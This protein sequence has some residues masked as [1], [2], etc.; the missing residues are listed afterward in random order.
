MTTTATP[1]PSAP[2]LSA[3]LGQVPPHPL[4]LGLAGPAGCGKS[5]T[6]SLLSG[7]CGWARLSFADPLRQLLLALHPAWDLWH[8]GPGKDLTPPDGGL[9]P[10]EMMR[11][12]GDWAK[13]YVPGFFI[14]AAYDQVIRHWRANRHIVIDDVRF[15]AE[16]DF[17]R[18]QGGV[19]CHISRQEVSFRRDHNSELGIEPM[20]GD[21]H[22]KNW[23]GLHALRDELHHVLEGLLIQ[24]AP[25]CPRPEASPARY[26]A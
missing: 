17:V 1:G 26:L 21:L 12:A 24:A 25:P 5:T 11:A 3:V 10:R 2:A 8:L 22:L 6:A 9:S 15:D 4:L 7:S 14:D 18:R 20:P 23:G 13:A 19:I 16:A